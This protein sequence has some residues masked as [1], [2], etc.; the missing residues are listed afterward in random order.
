MLTLR[1]AQRN[2]LSR[3]Q[4]HEIILLRKKRYFSKLKHLGLEVEISTEMPYELLKRRVN[5]G[6]EN[7]DVIYFAPKIMEDLMTKFSVEAKYFSL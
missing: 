7:T 2:N 3:D 6:N 5:C 1:N 4:L